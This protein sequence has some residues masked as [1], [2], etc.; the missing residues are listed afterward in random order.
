M[1][2]VFSVAET[3]ENV[4][5]NQTDFKELIPEFYKPEGQGEFLNNI[6]GVDFGICQDG[7]RVADVR[8]PPW[9]KGEIKNSYTA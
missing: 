6:L 7:L 5:T 3:W 8:L 4:T 2:L 1:F 9:A